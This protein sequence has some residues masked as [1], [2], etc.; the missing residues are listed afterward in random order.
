MLHD[1]AVIVDLGG[2]IDANATRRQ[3]K[4]C[5][6]SAAGTYAR[7]YMALRRAAADFRACSGLPPF[8]PA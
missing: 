4:Q 2:R 5:S 6:A 7:K 8:R 3:A 1:R